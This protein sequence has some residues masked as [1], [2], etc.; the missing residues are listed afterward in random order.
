V[1]KLIRSMLAVG[2]LAFGFLLPG[3]LLAAQGKLEKLRVESPAL[4]GN[5]QGNDAT[6]DVWVYTPPG[7]GKGRKRYPVVYFL[8]G[9]AVTADIYVNDV[10]K[11]PA[12]TDEAMA[13]GAR[14]FIIVMPDAFTRFGGSWYSSSPTTGDW[15]SFITKDLVGY[16]DDRYR[17][18]AK[19]EGRGLAG[20]SMGGYGTLRIGMRYAETFGA[21]YAMSSAIL[22][23]AP[24]AEATKT[25]LARMTPDLRS[26]PRSSTNGP[27]SQASAWAPNPQN[28]PWFFDFPFDADGKAMPLVAEK[29]AANSPLVTVDQHV[30]RLKSLRGIALDCGD[31]DGLE[32]GNKRFSDALTRLGVQHSY[33]V[34][35]GTHGNRIGARFIANVLPFFAKHL[36]AK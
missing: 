8:H 36:D 6:R 35:E 11:I 21:I 27:Q 13:A 31:A 7:Y 16:I 5:L 26:E 25:Q 14:E 19:R 28:P 33:E 2:A 29:W 20:H 32:V 10:L 30:S 24:G 3:Q 15:E 18:I 12:A 34:Y 23:Q 17:T 22:L 4:A 1:L 9:Y